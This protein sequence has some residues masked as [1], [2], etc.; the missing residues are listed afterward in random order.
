VGGCR[1]PKTPAAQPPVHALPRETFIAKLRRLQGTPEE[2][3]QDAELM[4]MVLPTLRADFALCETYVYAQQP[5]LDC[6]ISA[7]GG[8]RDAYVSYAELLGWREQ[9]CDA[10]TLRM[11]PGDH[12]FLHP[13]RT[14]LLQAIADDLTRLPGLRS[15]GERA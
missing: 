12:F 5:P 2:V 11:F 9:T 14:P 8:L 1:A 4:D 7:F 13:L 3:L 6:A 10:F 15:P